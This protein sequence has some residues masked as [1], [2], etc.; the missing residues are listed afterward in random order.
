LLLLAD[1]L[2]KP[3]NHYQQI[4]TCFI[5]RKPLPAHPPLLL[6]EMGQGDEV[7]F[8]KIYD[9]LVVTILFGVS[10]LIRLIK[11]F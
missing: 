6:E 8:L 3:E 5:H 11:W 2:S 9:C 10:I 1:F 4:I 7:S